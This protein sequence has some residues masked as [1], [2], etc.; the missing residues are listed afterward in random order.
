MFDMVRMWLG[1]GVDGFRLDIFGSIM[2]DAALRDNDPQPALVGGIPRVQTPDPHAQHRRELRPRRRPPSGVR[3][4][5]ARD[6]VLLGEVFGSADVLRRYVRRRRSRRPAPGVPVRLPRPPA[7]AP[8]GTAADRALRARVPGAAAA[9]LRASR[10]TTALD[11]CRVS[12]ATWRRP[13]CW[14]PSLCT[15]RGVPVI[16][17]GQEIGMTNRYIPL[18]RGQRSHPVRRREASAGVG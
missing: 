2:H 17:Q 12:A 5:R 11:R 8:S 10:T 18:R 4:V 9:D 1:R 7:T 13:G 14:R 16:Y 15:L 6:R 3:R